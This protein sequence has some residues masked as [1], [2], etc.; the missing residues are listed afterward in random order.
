MG[1]RRNELAYNLVVR[2]NRPRLRHL[3]GK[4]PEF[5]TSDD[6]MLVPFGHNLIRPNFRAGK[7]LL[8]CFGRS[9]ENDTLN[10]PNEPKRLDFD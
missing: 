1:K 4:H 5:K 3:L 8:T 7:K 9:E 10:S 6:A 2:G